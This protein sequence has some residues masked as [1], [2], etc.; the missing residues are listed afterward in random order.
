MAE[1]ELLREIV[2][3]GDLP[4]TSVIYTSA[5][6]DKADD[7]DHGRHALDDKGEP[8]DTAT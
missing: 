5:S 1:D 4:A 8:E 6:P 2:Q 7:S 3:L